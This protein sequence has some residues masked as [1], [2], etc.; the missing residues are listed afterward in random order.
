MIDLFSSI[1]MYILSLEISEMREKPSIPAKPSL[2][3]MADVAQ[4]MMINNAIS[5]SPRGSPR[6]AKKFDSGYVNHEVYIQDCNF[7]FV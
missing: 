7:K 3:K 2:L 5:V 1:L 4:D 6:N